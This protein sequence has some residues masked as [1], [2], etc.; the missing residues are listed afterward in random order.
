MADFVH[1]LF[2]IDS[3]G[4]AT[5]SLNCPQ[6]MNG[7]TV[8]MQNE[9]LASLQLIRENHAC[10]ALVLTGSGRA[11]CAGAA[12]DKLQTSGVN[13]QSLGDS[14]AKAMREVS[15]PLIRTLSESPVPVVCAINGVVAGAGIG[16]ALAA[17][18]AI[19]ARSAN[20]VPTFAP[21][22]GLIPDLGVS[23]Q[24]PRRVGRARAHAWTLLGDKLSADTAVTW[25]LIWACVDDAELL[26]RAR[27]L[28]LKLSA[29]PRHV[30]Q[31][32]RD[33]YAHAEDASLAEQLEYEATHQATCLDSP[34]FEEGV[35]AFFERREPV[36]E[37]R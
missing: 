2:D 36:F 24:L 28:A 7:L 34:S 13:H 16:I 14:T 30:L 29:L 3:N 35:M 11:F 5:L 1:I 22:L 21:K 23:W 19:G 10:R 33:A 8:A 18:V 25:G 9:M 6:T 26:P 17:D 12:L 31:A 37:P 27:E 4:I 32:V 20:F 15:N